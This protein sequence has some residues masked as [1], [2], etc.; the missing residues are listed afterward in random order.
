VTARN[1]RIRLTP[2]GQGR[3]TRADRIASK[4]S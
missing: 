3:R 4:E 2:E 1:Y